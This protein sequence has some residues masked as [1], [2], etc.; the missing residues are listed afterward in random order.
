MDY[1]NLVNRWCEGNGAGWWD[2]LKSPSPLW[3]M[4]DRNCNL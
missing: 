4:I 2:Q 1:S 3:K